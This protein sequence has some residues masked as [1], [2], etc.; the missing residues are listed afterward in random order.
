MLNYGQKPKITKCSLFVLHVYGYKLMI[1]FFQQDKEDK[2]EEDDAQ[3]NIIS[4]WKSGAT[5]GIHL[6]CDDDEEEEMDLA[7]EG[8]SNSLL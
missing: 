6:A 8:W 4:K 3:V 7:P 5:T 2:G 1:S